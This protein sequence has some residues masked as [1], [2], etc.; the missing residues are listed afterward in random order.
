M[1]TLQD[2]LRAIK[3]N[4]H[5]APIENQTDIDEYDFYDDPGVEKF[6]FSLNQ[7]QSLVLLYRYMGFNPR[8]I[9]NLLGFKHTGSYRKVLYSLRKETKR[10]FLEDK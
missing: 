6:L 7:K 9:C 8:E 3:V 10:F 2:I 1:Y 5:S 4:E